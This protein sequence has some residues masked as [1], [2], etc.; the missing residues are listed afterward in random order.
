MK[1]LYSE[2]DNY[3]LLSGIWLIRIKVQGPCLRIRDS[4]FHS[5]QTDLKSHS[6]G[7]Y[8]IVSMYFSLHAY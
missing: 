6:S 1:K 5:I 8:F 7:S 3:S 4:L 2:K